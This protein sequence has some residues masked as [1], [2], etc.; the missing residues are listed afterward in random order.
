MAAGQNTAGQTEDRSPAPDAAEDNAFFPSP[1]SL[2]QYTA[3]KTDFDG[4]ATAENA[5]SGGRW[6]V[7][8]VATEE[9]YMLMDNGTM[10]S[11]GNHPVE[12]LLPLHH[13]LGAGFDVEVATLTGAPA[14][15]EWWAYPQEDEAVRAT[16]EQLRDRFKQPRVLSE[17]V[18]TE[19]G[20]DSDILGVFVPGGHGAMLGLPES[21]DLRDLLDWALAEEKAVITLC[22]GPAALLAAGL[23]R[24]QN[25]FSGYQICSFPDALDQGANIEIGYLPGKMPWALGEALVED[26]MELANQEMTGAVHQDRTLLTGDSPLAANALGKLAAQYLVEHAAS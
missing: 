1:C 6:K 24:E 14:K 17:V 18:A 12:T 21:L 22:H 26:G 19:L 23:D 10:F 7:L 16:W 9:R 13:L 8:V 20:Q 2:G 25:P 4:L 5:Y 3:P 15:F 11:T